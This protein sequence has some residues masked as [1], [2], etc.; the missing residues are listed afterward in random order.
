RA[1]DVGALAEMTAAFGRAHWIETRRD[2]AGALAAL[3]SGVGVPTLMAGL[4]HRDD[5]IRRSMFDSFFEATG[6]HESYDPDAPRPERLEAI[7]RLQ[8]TWEKT[9]GTHV[10]RLPREDAH[11]REE[12]WKEVEALGGGTD[13]LPGGDDAALSASL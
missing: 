8:S 7:A 5:V 6:L 10:R 4:D 3:G 13:V 9:G 2:L 11:R 12:A 1:N